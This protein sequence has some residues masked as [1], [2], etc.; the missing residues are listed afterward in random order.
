LLGWRIDASTIDSFSAKPF[1][2]RQS[3]LASKNPFAGLILA[4]NKFEAIFPAAN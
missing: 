3:D 1:H 4:D 2:L